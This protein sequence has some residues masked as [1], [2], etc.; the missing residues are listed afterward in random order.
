MDRLTLLLK[1]LPS[2]RASLAARALALGVF[3]LLV[4]FEGATGQR[5]PLALSAD[6]G[7][8]SVTP[9][10]ANSGKTVTVVID[11]PGLGTTT[12]HQS[13]STDF[14]GN[15]YELP[16]GG[17]SEQHIF[18][19]KNG[20]IADYNGDGKIGAG[21]LAVTAP[22][23]AVNW[24]NTQNGTFSLTRFIANA[25]PVQFQV[26]YRSEVLDTATVAVRS[27]A[28]IDGFTLTVQE[29]GLATNL[30]TGT[31]TTGTATTTANISVPGATPRPAIKV[32]DGGIVTVEYADASPPTLVSDAIIIDKTLPVIEVTQPVN[33]STTST[34]QTWFAADVTDDRAG[35]EL[36]DIAFHLD[37]DR[38]GVFDEPG[39][40]LTPSSIVSTHINNGWAAFAQITTAVNDGTIPW[41]VTA[42]DR[43]GNTAR[44]D[45]DA[46]TTGDQSHKYILD[47]KPPAVSAVLLGDN[48]D[49]VKERDL[50]NQT[51][52]IR[53]NFDED[54][55]PD[56]VVA[57]RFIFA[58]KTPV[59]AV[60]YEDLPKSVFLKYEA[61]P[62]IAEPMLILAGAVKD[63]PGL[64]NDRTIKPVTDHLGPTLEVLFDTVIAND[65]V[66]VT[67]R[68]PETLAAAPTIEIN[69]VTYGAMTPTGNYLEWSGTIDDDFLTGSALGDGV[70]NVEIAGFDKPGNRAHGGIDREDPL[71]PAGAHTYE[72]DRVIKKPTVLP[73]ANETVLV[74]NPV[75]TVSYPEEPLE[76]AGDTHGSV[77]IIAATLDG[78]NV[79]SL[80]S[81][82]SAT[83]WLFQPASLAAGQHEFIVQARD[84]AGNIHGAFTLV[85]TVNAAATPAPTITPTPEATQTPV[86]TVNPGATL[87]AGQFG[88]A[89][90]EPTVEPTA[91]GVPTPTPTAAAT[92]E[93]L[94]GEQTPTPGPAPTPTVASSVDVE[95]TVQAIR[96]GE[97]GEGQEPASPLDPQPA[98]TLYGCGLPVGNAGV[99]GGDYLIM[100]AGLAGLVLISRR[101]K[102]GGSE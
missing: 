4:L 90:P 45:A 83:T 16:P 38:D 14:T 15:P 89:T 102:R 76:Y 11:D 41:Y 95:A 3:A 39:E 99:A 84:D 74:T 13:E 35:L 78:F 30:F 34:V 63:V 60:V 17:A 28:D 100:G 31:F 66:A 25:A 48:Y 19:V 29:T 86:G 64:P 79:T 40:I 68:S 55:D 54:L 91:E 23:V 24:V 67:A 21:D 9:D 77:T 75:I 85:F 93:P 33:G 56:T 71:W 50:T 80:M 70:K 62:S 82:T 59:S 57:G 22:D 32:E 101:R 87:P 98:Y 69:G 61:I 5:L 58:D 20:P 46:T 43:A 97:N 53:V 10:Y 8:L 88:T 42:T 44:T 1:A 65:K 92:Q 7:V 94:S 27:S 72:L 36:S 12:L 52:Y 37:L 51:D 73:S 18:R 96:N 2:P 49:E 6:G 81:E 26:T 47:T